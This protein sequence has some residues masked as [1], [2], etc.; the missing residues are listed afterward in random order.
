MK[1]ILV[2]SLALIMACASVSLA[3]KKPPKKTTPVKPAKPAYSQPAATS[4]PAAAQPI[5]GSGLVIS[6]KLAFGTSGLSAIAL[7][8]EVAMPIMS[9]VSAMGEIEYY[10]VSGGS[11]MQVAGNG[12]YTFAP[13]TGAPGTFY[14]GGGVVYQMISGANVSGIGAQGFGGMDFPIP[15]AGTAFGQIKYVIANYTTPSVTIG[16][17]TVPG[18]SVSSGGFVLEGGYRFYL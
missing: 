4:T 17:F 14:A 7:G 3:A 13:V 18:V 2:L 10:A 5:K 12:V 9:Q 8:C 15:G 1:K 16:G 11:V 6:P